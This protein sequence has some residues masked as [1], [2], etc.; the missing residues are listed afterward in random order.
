MR[1]AGS[2]FVSAVYGFLLVSM[3]AYAWGMPP[4]LEAM[5]RASPVRD[6]RGRSRD[7]ATPPRGARYPGSTQGT[8]DFWVLAV[9][10]RRPHDQPD[11]T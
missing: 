11:F 2:I 5:D 10:Q 9:Q 3:F 8:G 1:R 6:D 7:L 4:F